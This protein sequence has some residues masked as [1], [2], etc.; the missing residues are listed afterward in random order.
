MIGVYNGAPYL[1]EAI[2]SVLAQT[3]RRIE[4]LVVDDGSEDEK[5]AI[6]RAYGDRTRRCES[7]ER[8]NR[9]REKPSDPLA[10]GRYSRSSM[11]TTVSYRTS[12]SAS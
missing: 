11:P 1:A 6:A 5:R 3:L 8:R 12:S 2:D 7:A 10:Q 4:L 9:R